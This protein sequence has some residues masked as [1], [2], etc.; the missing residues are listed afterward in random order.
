MSLLTEQVVRR[1]DWIRGGKTGVMV[2]YLPSVLSQDRILDPP[3]WEDAVNAFDVGNFCRQIADMGAEWLIFPF[4]QNCGKYCAPNPVLDKY[5]PGY[6][7]RRN[8]LKEIALRLKRENIK[9]IAYLPAEVCFREPEFSQALGWFDDE[10]KSIFQQRYEEIVR[11]WA[12]DLGDAIDGWWFDGCYTAS[13]KSFV[14]E[15]DNRWTNARFT[16]SWYDA[17][18]AGN[19]DVALAMCHGANSFGYV[20]PEQDYLAGEVNSLLEPPVNAPMQK[21]ALLNLDLKVWMFR[22]D[23]WHPEEVPE[24]EEPRF[25]YSE[26]LEWTKLCKERDCGITFNIGIFRSGELFEKSVDLVTKINRK[27]KNV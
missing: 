1:A 25:D 20:S 17:V 26:L 18:R 16:S 11:Y 12:V 19:P 15:A 6:T 21:H 13:E 7:C 24:I 4:G 23:P 22:I 8:L 27:V 9:T 10:D 5:I 2:H 3:E 14:P